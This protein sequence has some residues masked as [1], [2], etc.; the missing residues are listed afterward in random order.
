MVSQ[1]SDWRSAAE[2]A[3]ECRVGSVRE[4]AASTGLVQETGE[5]AGEA[6]GGS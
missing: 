1:M 3:P 6:N 4:Q 2:P 5:G